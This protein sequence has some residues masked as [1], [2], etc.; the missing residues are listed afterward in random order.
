MRR[1]PKLGH[2]RAHPQVGSHET[3]AGI[4]EQKNPHRPADAVRS[5]RGIDAKPMTVE[6]L[7]DILLKNLDAV[8]LFDVTYKAIEYRIRLNYLIARQ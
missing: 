3:L 8:G 6:L 5:D 7:R 4:G 1:R 2:R